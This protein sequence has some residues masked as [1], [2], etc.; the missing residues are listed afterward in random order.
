M[1]KALDKH[2]FPGDE[3]EVVIV[4]ESPE[5]NTGRYEY[6]APDPDAG[7]GGDYYQIA[8][9]GIAEEI[10]AGLKNKI[11]L[12]KEWIRRTKY[13]D[14]P[15][16]TLEEYLIRIAAHEARHRVQFRRNKTLFSKKIGKKVEDAYLQQ[17]IEFI[18]LCCRAKH[19]VGVYRLEFDA[20][21][22]EYLAAELWHDGLRDA[23]KIALIV[24]T[25]AKKMPEAINRIGFET[26]PFFYPGAAILPPHSGGEAG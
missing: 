15:A 9:I 11:I 21:V 23:R 18:D 4:P 8:G 12:V 7:I 20:R 14:L 10:S 13:C 25:G 2:V 17:L 24:G 5:E 3:A 16:I 6:V 1:I 26:G 19:P 22:V